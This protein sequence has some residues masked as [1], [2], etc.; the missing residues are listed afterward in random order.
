ME[1]IIAGAN[2]TILPALFIVAVALFCAGLFELAETNRPGAGLACLGA[3][4][5]LVF[6]GSAW[7][8]AIA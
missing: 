7:V 6:T 2:W 3:S 1:H 8:D 4:L 5:L